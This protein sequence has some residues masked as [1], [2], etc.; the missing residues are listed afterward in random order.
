[1]QGQLIITTPLQ[2][3]AQIS[4]QD[5]QSFT[6]TNYFSSQQ[7]FTQVSFIGGPVSIGDTGIPTVSI[8]RIYSVLQQPPPQYASITL[9][10]PF[11]SDSFDPSIPQTGYEL[12]ITEGR[13]FVYITGYWVVSGAVA[14]PE[15]STLFIAGLAA[16]CGIA[17][18]AAYKRR[19]Q[20][21]NTNGA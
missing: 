5:I 8:T 4:T 17:H 14:V 21:I 18:A 12:A 16:V 10:V 13:E 3:P 6:F 1:V 20:R 2:T 9:S 11:N 7:P 15:P 19:A